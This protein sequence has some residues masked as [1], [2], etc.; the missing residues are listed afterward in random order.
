MRLRRL[1]V[2]FTII[3]FATVNL[4]V[5]S[6]EIQ[7]N[8]NKQTPSKTRNLKG[9]VFDYKAEFIN[10][11]WWENF[12]DPILIEYILKA[13]SDNN[14]LKTAGLRVSEAKAILIETLG[15]EFPIIA[16]GADYQRNKTS[17]NIAMGNF[18]IPSYTQNTFNFPFMMNYELDLWRKNRIRTIGA[19]KQLEATKYDERASYISLTSTVATVYFNLIKTD[20]LIDIQKQL[21][22]LKT[23]QQD[24]TLEKYE[25]GLCP[26]SDYLNSKKQLL[27]A[28][29][30][31]ADMQK[32]SGIL[33]NQLS[34]LVGESVD[35]SVDLR[36]NSIDSVDFVKE[37]PDSIK[38]DIVKRRPDILKAEA[39]LQKYKI[40]EEIARRDFLPNIDIMGQFGFMANSFSKT[41]V[42][43][44]YTASFGTSLMQTIFSGGQRR[45]RLK[46]KKFQYQEMLE[47]YQKTILQSFQEIND[48]FAVLKSD[49]LKYSNNLDRLNCENENLNLIE[50]K[51]EAGSISYLDT[52]EY[53]VKQLNLQKEIIQSKTDCLVDYLS[54]YKASGGQL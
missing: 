39:L 42:W 8:I 11:E 17:D 9:S 18:K 35:T 30:T 53:K 22:E 25:N 43:D 47:S 41:F 33:L 36:R 12:N 13:A 15:K 32:Q 40:D 29:N 28:Q 46:A 23:N 45:A 21:V 27:E 16:A 26:L 37:L 49:N 54:L 31:L 6:K 44:S 1:V 38:S 10:Q 52:L 7:A 34:V 2:L 4:Q 14:D 5:L 24:L 3:S 51:Y 50:S 20:K 48:S 19:S